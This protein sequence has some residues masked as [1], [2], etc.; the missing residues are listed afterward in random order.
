M[1]VLPVEIPQTFR[2]V[3]R[4]LNG[5]RVLG[6]QASAATKGENSANGQ[7]SQAISDGGYFTP[8]MQVLMQACDKYVARLLLK[9]EI[10]AAPYANHLP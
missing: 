4:L 10:K 5:P 8:A 7:H 2:S 9:A 1:N 6:G 3:V